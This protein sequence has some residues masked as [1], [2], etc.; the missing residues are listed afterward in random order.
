MIAGWLAGVAVDVEHQFHAVGLVVELLNLHGAV[1][2]I[3]FGEARE[4]LIRSLPPSRLRAA[5]YCMSHIN[6]SETNGR[7]ARST[8]VNLD[9]NRS[10]VVN[11]DSNR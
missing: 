7:H 11:I 10:T 9:S 8:V 1:G 3:A 6:L 5:V 2:R 4:H